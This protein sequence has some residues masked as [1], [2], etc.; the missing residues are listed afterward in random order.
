[1]F[2]RPLYVCQFMDGRQIGMLLVMI[3]R[4][5]FTGIINCVKNIIKAVDNVCVC[6]IFV[7]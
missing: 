6:T 2:V 4:A 7:V 3:W 1:M 5:I